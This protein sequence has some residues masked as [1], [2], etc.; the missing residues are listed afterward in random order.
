MDKKQI[1]TVIKQRRKELKLTARELAQKAG[2]DRTY[3]S[4]IE[5]QNLIPELE[6][7]IKIQVALDINLMPFYNTG[8]DESDI[9]YKTAQNAYTTVR[10]EPQNAKDIIRKENYLLNFFKIIAAS[11]DEPPQK[12]ARRIIKILEPGIK[13]TKENVEVYVRM[14]QGVK[15]VRFKSFKK[16]ISKRNNSKV[17][18]IVLKKVKG[19]PNKNWEVG[20][21]W[22]KGAPKQ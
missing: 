14:V 4:K 11:G 13:A 19:Y 5:N 1:G 8:G 3:V 22:P 16:Y 10:I 21:P 6:K 7:L 2:I 12:T 15:E 20:D 18:P 9:I 17:A